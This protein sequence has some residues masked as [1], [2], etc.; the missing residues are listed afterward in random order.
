MTLRSKARAALSAIPLADAFFRR[1]VWSRSHFPEAEMRFLHRLP[2]DAFDVAIDVGAAL[3]GY[4]WILNRKARR[5]IAFEP[6]RIH[7][8]FLQ[9]GLVGTRIELVRAAVG[10]EEGSVVL[11]TPGGDTAALHSATLSTDNPVVQGQ[12]VRTSTVPQLHLD[13]LMVEKLRPGERVDF[14]KVDVEGYELAVFEGAH[15]LIERDKP[16]I[17]CEIEARHNRD[18]HRVFALLRAL[19]YS[20]FFFRD[21]RFE[22]FSGDDLEHLQQDRDLDYRLSS[23]YDARMNRYINNFTFC[24][25][26]SRIQLPA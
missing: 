14:L 2:G 25:P 23:S 15:A 11:Y 26:H 6:G 17:I 1:V 16:L 8:D 12:D 10:R 7:A 20:A 3:G 4:A 24:H 5:V 19:G 21:G 9:K 22:L 18:Y 13:G